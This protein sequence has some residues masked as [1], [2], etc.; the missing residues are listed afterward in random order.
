MN[1]HAASALRVYPS[2]CDACRRKKVKCNRIKPCAQCELRGVAEECYATAPRISPGTR[3]QPRVQSSASPRPIDRTEFST[4]KARRV[5]QL[6]ASVIASP[7]STG[8]TPATGLSGDKRADKGKQREDE[9][10]TL[11]ASATADTPV[12]WED[13]GSYLTS[14]SHCIQLFDFFFDEVRREQCLES[15]LVTY[16][17]SDLVS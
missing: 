4:H 14:A 8:D 3:R 17:L 11:L 2:N 6:S 1:G 10:P 9:G 16:S 7:A 12:Q 13:V 5:D 15:P